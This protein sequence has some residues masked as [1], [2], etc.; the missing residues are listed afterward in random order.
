[1]H[2]KYRNSCSG[3][4]VGIIQ[5]NLKMMG[6]DPKDIDCI[7]GKNTEIAVKEFQGVNGLVTD[8][9]VGSETSNSLFKNESSY[10]NS[11]SSNFDI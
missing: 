3:A 8:G 11:T 1:M 10:S 6:Y 5:N 7:F 2:K 4:E 9:I